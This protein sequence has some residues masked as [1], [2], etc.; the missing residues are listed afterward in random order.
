MPNQGDSRMC[1]THLSPSKTMLIHSQ[2]CYNCGGTGH[3]SRDCTEPTKQK[4]SCLKDHYFFL[5]PSPDHP[6]TCYNCGEPGHMSRDCPMGNSGGGRGGMS[7]GGGFGGRYSEGGAAGGGGSTECYKC[8]KRSLES[9][10][11]TLCS[12]HISNHR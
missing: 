6:Q 9:F 3:L 8:G 12:F 2:T 10:R 7:G 1:H 11:S 4:V 5:N